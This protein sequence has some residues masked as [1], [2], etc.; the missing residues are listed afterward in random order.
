MKWLLTLALCGLVA[1]AGF[2]LL[3]VYIDNRSVVSIAQDVVR[4]TELDGKPKKLVQSALAA[5]FY[6]R[7]LH[8]LDPKEVVSIARDKS[9]DLVLD[10]K[11]EER[12]PLLYNLEIVAAFDDQISR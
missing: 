3:P 5:Q 11:Y 6:E 8:H 10:I 7:S 1:V 12:R 9:G 4:D 2:R